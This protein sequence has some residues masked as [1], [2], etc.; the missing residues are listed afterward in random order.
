[1]R[2]GDIA[3]AASASVTLKWVDMPNSF[4]IQ[5]ENDLVFCQS[6]SD[7]LALA[8]A[9]QIVR[10]ADS[11]NRSRDEIAA[12]SETCG[13]YGLRELAE[14]LRP[15]EERAHLQPRDTG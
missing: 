11:K 10:T 7:R 3:F 14:K 5:I 6:E 4:P 13:E 2:I 9:A 8:V 12:L 1:M 15:F